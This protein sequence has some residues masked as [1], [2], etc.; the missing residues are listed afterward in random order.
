[1]SFEGFG[2][3]L[4][5]FSEET[6][7][8]RPWAQGAYQFY[9][10]DE[11]EHKYKILSYSNLTAPF[12]TSLFPQFILESVMK[13]ALNDDSFEFNVKVSSLPTPADVLDK[14]AFM[15]FDDHTQ[16]IEMQTMS[17][18]VNEYTRFSA[19][20]IGCVVAAW[21]IL[22]AWVVVNLIR[23]RTSERK[24]FL[25]SHGQSQVAYWVSRY[26]HDI[27]FYL[28]ISVVAIYLI[29]VYE[30]QMDAAALS[31]AL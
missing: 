9:E 3:Q 7:V 5:K 4:F 21:F 29:S 10:M 15:T 19:E 16:T 24:M 28:P 26:I 1:M 6:A 22:N 14:G 31:V 18:V 25:Q 17:E 20:P 2:K 30:T 13:T 8:E 27:V 12:S 23:E 11:D